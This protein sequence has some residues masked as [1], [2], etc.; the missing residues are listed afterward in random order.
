[1]QKIDKIIVLP[2]EKM[3]HDQ[4][5]GNDVDDEVL[6]TREQLHLVQALKIGIDR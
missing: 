1:M 6:D 2:V 5:V 3:G 4:T